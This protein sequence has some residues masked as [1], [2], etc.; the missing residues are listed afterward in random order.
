MVRLWLSTACPQHLGV[1]LLQPHLIVSDAHRPYHDERAWQLLLKV[2]KDLKPKAIT[3]IGDFADFYTVSSHSKSPDRANRLPEELKSVKAGLDD[4]DKL[5]AEDK[6]FVEGNHEDRLR[7]M[8]QDKA[9]EFHGIVDVPKLFD[10][11]E[12]GWK[13]V[14]YKDDIR[15]GK[16]YFTHDVGTAGR[17]SVYRALDTYQHSVVTGHSHRFSYVVEGNA[18]GEY[19]VSAA[20]GWLGDVNKIEYMHRPTARKN[21]AL[22]FGVGYLNPSTG[23]MYLVPV[24]IVKHSCV[25]N[26]R[27]YTA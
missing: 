20:F 15:V 24:P 5:G 21:W 18:V 23:I 17:Y 7:R 8:L 2:G 16:L 13:Y 14:P 4:L 25:V 27:L 1:S 12:R 6:I 3:I 9:P 22:G 26:G 11:K 10:L 19:K